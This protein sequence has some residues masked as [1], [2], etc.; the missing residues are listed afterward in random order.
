VVTER[1]ILSIAEALHDR[2]CTSQRTLDLSGSDE[3]SNPITDKATYEHALSTNVLYDK[4][5]VS[6]DVSDIQ[7]ALLWMKLRGYVSTFGWGIVAPEMGYQL[8]DKGV[9]LAQSRAMPRE[10]MQRL[11]GKA[12][13]VK[14]AMYGVSLDLKELW[15]RTKK[16][17]RKRHG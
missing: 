1:I 3:P 6:Y 8:T 9:A 14:P 2:T 12:I 5:L 4:L 13:S 15:W 10:D 7:G 17:L 11:S 16:L